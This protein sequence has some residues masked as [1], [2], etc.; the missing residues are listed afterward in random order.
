MFNVGVMICTLAD[1]SLNFVNQHQW[2]TPSSSS[3]RCVMVLLD[4][5]CGSWWAERKHFPKWHCG[6][7]VPRVLNRQGPFLSLQCRAY[8]FSLAGLIFST[9]YSR[10]VHI[11]PFS[12]LTRF[13]LLF[14][15]SLFLLHLLHSLTVNLGK[16]SNHKMSW[17]FFHQISLGP[18]S[19]PYS[20]F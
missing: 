6:A 15:F 18:L 16:G 14:S 8:G 4:Y 1:L 12:T 9:I 10:F 2:V 19:S 17:N 3:L 20:C 11:F 5:N 13:K 7:G